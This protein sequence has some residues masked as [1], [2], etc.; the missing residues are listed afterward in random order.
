MVTGRRIDNSRKWLVLAVLVL[1][2]FMAI[3]DTS[4]VNIAIPKMMAVFCVGTEQ[5]QWVLTAY[6]LTMGAI[7]PLTGYLSDRFGSKKVYIWALIAFTLGSA[8]CGL[9]WSNPSMVVARVIQALGGGMIMPV[10]MSILYQVIPQQERGLA[11]GIWGIAAM[12]APAIGPTL[13][14][15][16]VE[17]LDWRL[18]FT[19]NIPVGIVAVI[20][21]FIL[22]PEIP[23]RPV[24]KF[25]YLGVLFASV[26]LVSILYVLGEGASIDWN[27]IKNIF[28]L[29]FGGFFLLLFTVNEL[30]HSDP[31][32]DLR[33]LKIGPF[34]LSIVI[35][36]ITNIA[37]FGGIFLLPLF[38]QNLRGYTAMQTGII[39]FP[40]AV[41]T[42][43]MMPIGG[44]L[45]DRLGPKPVVIP[46]LAILALAT[47]ELAHLS[48]ETPQTTITWL[49]VLRGLG[50]GLAM[51]PASTAGMNAV[52]LPL[53]A[54]AS[55]LS[56]VVRQV[57]GSLGITILTTFMQRRQALHY[58]ELAARVTEFNGQELY[59]YWLYGSVQKEALITAINDTLALT[60]VIS[61]VALFFAFWLKKGQTPAGKE[62][63][64]ISE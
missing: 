30:T 4:I 57:A 53:V 26:G 17:H 20:F 56:N 47:Y 51:M 38:L 34:T 33:V 45:L 63:V 31:L 40:S 28:L 37:L 13:S 27:D 36:S 23:R 59:L 32:L 58:S 25:D 41:A 7:I 6:M 64:I 18:I 61:C 8:F 48:M 62:Q 1:G 42:G 54:R 3:L 39:M 43:L 60:A 21:S 50:L 55:A 46:G 24:G 29:I 12:A 49:L 14:G 2:T 11:L 16:I 52:P 5:I 19:I 44:K 15:Y 10:S 22:L 35:A 9:A